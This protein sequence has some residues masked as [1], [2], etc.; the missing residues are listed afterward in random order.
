MLKDD[1]P[2]Y[3]AWPH[4]LQ[5]LNVAGITGGFS[6]GQKIN[7][8]ASLSI[9]EHHVHNCTGLDQ[10]ITLCCLLLILLILHV[11]LLL[12]LLLLLILLFL[13]PALLICLLHPSSSSFYMTCCHSMLCS[14]SL[15]SKSWKKLSPLV[16]IMEEAFTTGQNH[17]R[18]FHHWSK[19]SEGYYPQQHF[20]QEAVEATVM[21]LSVFVS[22]QGTLQQASDRYPKVTV[23]FCIP[24]VSSSKLC[25]YVLCFLPAAFCAGDSCF[26]SVMQIRNAHMAMFEVLYPR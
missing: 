5:H 8:F 7:Q 10:Y 18:S 13:F 25:C 20:C 24:F 17:G 1:L 12:L 6:C 4:L 9:P 26:A 2:V 15:R 19:C 14:H 11:L 21:Y 23:I 3:W 22:K 16:K